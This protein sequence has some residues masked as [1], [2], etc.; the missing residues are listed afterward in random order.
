MRVSVIERLEDYL[1]IIPPEKKGAV[2]YDAEEDYQSSDAD[3]FEPFKDLCKRRFLWYYNSY[4]K[5][6]NEVKDKH[7]ENAKFERMPFEGPSNE[8]VGTFQYERL[9]NRLAAIREALEKET[10]NWVDEGLQASKQEL[11]IA[12]NLQRQFEQTTDHFEHADSVQLDFELVQGNPFVWKVVLFGPPMSNLDGGIF[13]IKIYLSTHFPDI[14]PRVK[15]E[16]PLFHHRIS[17]DG[18]LCYS[19]RRTDDLKSHIE[20]IVEAIK[21]ENPT[22]DPRT[23]VNPEASA[24]FWGTPEQKK[25]Y[26]RQL[27]RSAQA[28]FE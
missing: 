24:L 14:Q 9:L 11:S 12:N 20:A 8:M 5:K 25:L 13:N 26:S 23:L 7:K 27:R 10:L 1:K 22:Y 4:V 28:S 21:D 16:T 17:K 19:P 6:I 3:V 2:R 15:V 18:V